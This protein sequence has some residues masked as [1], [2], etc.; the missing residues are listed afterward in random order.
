MSKKLGTFLTGVAVGA[1]IGVLYAPKKGSETREDLKEL[2]DD[3]IGRIRDI[4]IEDVKEAISL[5][6]ADIKQSISE[7]DKEKILEIAKEKGALLKAKCEDLIVFAK[8]KGIPAVEKK[9]K[10]LK[11]KTVAV[12][13]EVVAKLEERKKQKQEAQ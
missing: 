7:L 9:A 8:E 13:K 3:I 2:I 10:E 5:K 11:E 6:I 12:T 4:D 1:A